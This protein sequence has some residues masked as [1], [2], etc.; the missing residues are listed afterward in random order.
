MPNITTHSA[1][2]EET[3]ALLQFQIIGTFLSAITYGLIISLFWHCL[4]MFTTTKKDYYSR[5]TRRFLIAYIVIMFLMSTVAIIQEIVSVVNAV[6]HGVNPNSR[7]LMQL[8]E[9]LVL[10][11]AIW[12]A[13]GFMLRRCMILY[14]DG[15]RLQRTIVYS[16]LLLSAIASFGCG[17]FYYMSPALAAF[18][19]KPPLLATT[20]AISVSTAVNFILTTLICGRLWFHQEGMRRVL[21]PHYGSPYM[22]VIVMCSAS[23]LLIVVTSL[24]YIGLFAMS[25]QNRSNGSVIPLL[26]LPH[27]CAISPIFIVYHVARGRGLTTLSPADILTPN[28]D[29]SEIGNSSVKE[30][31]AIQFR[32]QLSRST[33]S[34]SSRNSFC[35][36][37]VNLEPHAG[38]N[39]GDNR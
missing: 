4:I 5:R 12:G 39:I 25:D 31:E 19:D 37:S 9:P 3:A 15:S 33:D 18:A 34:S 26:L 14:M 10:P 38:E 8:N 22:R 6:V 28:I 7:H 13:D 27:V 21:G 1:S 24:A 17:I 29:V 35:G 36:I 23:C 2:N 32:H 11:F 20:M 30:M 16:I